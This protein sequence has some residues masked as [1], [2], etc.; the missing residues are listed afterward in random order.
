MLSEVKTLLPDFKPRRVL[1][2]GCGPATAGAAAV[3]VWGDDVHKYSGIDI[4]AAM[5]DAAKIVMDGASDIPV[6]GL[7][8]EGGR[9]RSNSFDYKS[10]A[11]KGGPVALANFRNS[12]GGS[13]SSGS[14]SG[15]K[16][17]GPSVVLWNKSGDV[18]KRAL[19]AGDRYDLVVA[20][21]TLSEMINDPSRRAAVQMMYELLDVNGCIVVLESGNPQG[22]HTVRTARQ[23]ILDH[24]NDNSNSRKVRK[25]FY[26]AAETRSKYGSRPQRGK[27]RGSDLVNVDDADLDGYCAQYISTQSCVIYFVT[28]HDAR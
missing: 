16:I 2:F 23:F 14:S 27:G 18:M 20:S 6:A 15:T 17:Q 5:L 9:V 19:S 26:R 25:E 22:S 4:S 24:F 13:S 12:T 8:A 10:L 3:H 11:G 7:L 21:Y 1:D 28:L